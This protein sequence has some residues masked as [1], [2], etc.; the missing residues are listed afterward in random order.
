[1]KKTCHALAALLCMALCCACLSALS[2][3]ATA[4]DSS[5]T[6][7]ATDGPMTVE[8]AEASG[9]EV[10]GIEDEEPVQEDAS[11]EVASIAGLT[12]LYTTKIKPFTA[13]GGGIRMRTKQDNQS[14]IVCILKKN[15]V[16]TIYKVYPSYVLCEFE[17]HVGF[18]IRTWID[19]NCTT[20][21]PSSTPPYGVVPMKYVA[22]ATAACNVYTQ[23]STASAAN[24]IVVGA[25][26]K[27]SIL[28]FVNGFAKV[29]YYRS[30][31]Y[32]DATLLTDLVVVSPTENPLSN[33][34]PIAAFCSFFAYNT[35]ASGND[36]RCKNIVRSCELMTRTMQVG[37]ELNFNANIGPYKKANGYFPAPVL[38]AG[39]S[40]LGYG[41]GTCQSSSTLYN[42]VRQ[43]NGVTVL[44]RRPHGPGC[45][46]YLPMHQDAAVGNDNLNFIFRNDCEYPFRIVAESTGEGTICIQIFRVD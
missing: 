28:E 10:E 44:M 37:E 16:I 33:D 8:E 24:S 17:G 35:G 12:P 26:S 34:T 3:T 31:G 15:D 43:L 21:D 7:A 40:Q 19:E 29:L 39:G 6:P 1:M 13:D 18:I 5:P 2:E 22:T 25:G 36:G 38:I 20:I 4:A 9:I 41:G 45:A 14:D 27:I 30:Y 23:P 11:G 46:R 42:T 32:V